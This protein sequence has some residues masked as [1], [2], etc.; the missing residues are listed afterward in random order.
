[1]TPLP[2]KYAWLYDEPGPRLLR[3]MLS[4]YGTVETL[5]AKNNPTILGWAKEIGL[6]HVY[7]NDSIAWC[8]LAVGFAAAQA[9]WEYAPRG[10]ALW[11]RNWLAWGTP[12]ALGKEMLGDVLVFSRG[13]VSGHVAVYVAE[14]KTHFHIIGGNQSDS[15]SIT[16]IEK[17]RLLM[18]RRCPWRVSQPLNVRKIWMN[19]V[20]EVSRGEA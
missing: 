7:K 13:A 10:N 3:E 2:K 16:R 4:M 11:A 8:G 15:V 1:M 18:G 12:V 17:S 14:D 6:G 9:G 19:S 5:G 20:G